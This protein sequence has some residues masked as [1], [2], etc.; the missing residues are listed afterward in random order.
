MSRRHEQFLTG[1][2]LRAC[3]V[4]GIV[5]KEA[6]P[7]D[8]ARGGLLPSLTAL[9][10]AMEFSGKTIATVSLLTGIPVG[11]VAHIL[12]KDMQ[13]STFKERALRAE[14]EQYRRAARALENEMA[15]QGVTL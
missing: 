15:R 2:E 8:A 10:A 4:A 5:I 9:P 14:T 13:S 3:S 12:H 6:A 1:D 7:G 11:I